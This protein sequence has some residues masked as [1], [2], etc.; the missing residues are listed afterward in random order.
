MSENIKCAVCFTDLHDPGNFPE[1]FPD[2]WKF[3][4]GCMNAADNIV[5]RGIKKVIEFYDFFF[6][7]KYNHNYKDFVR[8]KRKAEK[9]NKL[10]TVVG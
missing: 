7:N 4:C 9:L 3:C 5:N 1:D 8:Y 10:I 6:N 2:E